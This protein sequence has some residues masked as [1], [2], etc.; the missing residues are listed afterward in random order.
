MKHKKMTYLLGVVVVLVWGLI[1]YRL[2]SSASNDDPAPVFAGSTKKQPY[3]DY[4]VPK[5]TTHLLLN[6]RDPFG[7]V[8]FK[9]T[10]AM[11]VKRIL[12][13][14]PAPALIKPA[15]N[16][17]FIQYAGYVRNPASKKLIA[18]VTI[19]GK[20]ETLAE[21]E[22]KERVKLIK[23]FRDSI[24]VSFNGLTKCIALK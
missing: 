1:I 6:Y 3:N 21:G 14:S 16:W 22:S 10:D 17:G 2:V 8:K 15:M 13:K 7:L 24:K 5:D 11:P 19:N 9:D 12:H 4:S 18:L 20:N 23:N